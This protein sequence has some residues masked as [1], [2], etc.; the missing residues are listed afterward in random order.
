MAKPRVLV[1]GGNFAGLGSAQEIRRFCGEAVDITVLDRKNY[2]L[3]VP[4]IPAEVFEGRDPAK[5]LRMDIPG[6]LDEDRIE[7]VQG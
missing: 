6:A 7:F 3:F 2:L 4:N 5:S 1:L